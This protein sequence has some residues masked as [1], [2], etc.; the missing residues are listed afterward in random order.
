MAS[1]TTPEANNTAIKKKVIQH[2]QVFL[3]AP[4]VGH[5]RKDVGHLRKKRLTLQLRTNDGRNLAVH[6]HSIVDNIA[7]I[8]ITN[9]SRWTIEIDAINQSKLILYND[10]MDVFSTVGM[11]VELGPCSRSF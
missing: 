11:G 3:R 8:Q 5:F 4:S 7:L 6:V 1:T 9:V 2:W 10:V